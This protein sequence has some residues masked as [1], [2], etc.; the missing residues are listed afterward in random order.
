MTN[1]YGTLRALP[2]P[3]IPLEEQKKIIAH[4]D[5]VCYNIDSAT[6]KLNVEVALL[7]EYRKYTKTRVQMGKKMTGT[8]LHIFTEEYGDG[9]AIPFDVENKDLYQLCQS[10]FERFNIIEPPRINQQRTL[11]EV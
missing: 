8:H 1:W 4:L 7:G 5:K 11:L 3:I 10:F 9:Y 6:D 2:V